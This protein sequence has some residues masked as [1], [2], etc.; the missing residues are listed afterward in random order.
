LDRDPTHEFLSESDVEQKLVFP[1]LCSDRWLSI[2][3]S[4][5]KTKPFLPTADI[6]KGSHKKRLYSPD[7][8]VWIE[9]LPSLVVEAKA[10]DRDP[11]EGYREAQLYAQFLNVGLPAQQNPAHFVIS[12]NG[13]RLLAGTWDSLPS[14]DIDITELQYGS[15]YWERIRKAFH[16]NILYSRTSKLSSSLNQRNLHFPIHFLGG[17][18]RLGVRKDLNSFSL[19]LAQYLRNYFETDNSIYEDDILRFG[20]V[21][22]DQITK[23]DRIFEDHLR[24]TTT[25]LRGQKI[26]VLEPKKHSE[27]HLTSLLERQKENPAT[28]GFQLIIGGE[29]SGKSTFI[30]RFIAYLAP[31]ELQKVIWWVVIDVN[32]APGSTADLEEWVC[33]QFNASMRT[34]LG[35][36]LTLEQFETIFANH[37]RDFNVIWSSVQK[38]DPARFEREKAK[39]LTQLL[40][41]PRTLSRELARY[42]LGDRREAVVVFFDNVD[43]RERIQQLEIFQTAQFFKN[44]TNTLCIISLRDETFDR[45]K[46]EPPLDAFLTSVHFFIP[47][48]RF[49]D[50]VK[51]RLNLIMSRLK[52]ELSPTYSYSLNNGMTV[53]ITKDGVIEFIQTIYDSIF[54]DDRKGAIIFEALT[55]SDIRNALDLFGKSLTSG[56][57]DDRMITRQG[58]AG[59]YFEIPEH[60]IIRAL[61]R[62]EYLWYN[63][64]RSPIKNLFGSID[65]NWIFGSIARIEILDWLRK[66]RRISGDNNLN[67]FFLISGL[68]SDMEVY[69]LPKEKVFSEIKYLIETGLC[70]IDRF[71]RSDIS[72]SDYVKIHASG[73]MHLVLLTTRM[74]YLS[75]VALVTPYLRESHSEATAQAWE[76][77]FDS[78]ELLPSVQVKMAT[79]LHDDLDHKLQLLTKLGPQIDGLLKGTKF[80]MNNIEKARSGLSRVLEAQQQARSKAYGKAK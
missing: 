78:G 57:L 53:T 11:V 26:T 22:S 20:Y 52:S 33:N 70:Y 42:V 18:A 30:R 35:S 54:S 25:S 28:G 50:V 8:A 59:A 77:Q 40:G 37:M 56:H 29:G 15:I 51:L 72:D 39:H 60:L 27:S 68:L 74:E 36:D 41:D 61:M 32:K 12:T 46:S 14:L 43:R 71:S 31:P 66:R 38:T 64:G 2:P 75:A 55:G 73:W 4:A 62:G 47:P 24:Y 79:R 17:E 80:V 23:Y 44:H 49:Y 3:Q 34:Q 7:Y 76:R 21:S 13:S 19:P 10:P 58:V 16:Y 6:D 65:P 9:G 63:E 5:V 1:L 45:H 67:G 48:P 69:G